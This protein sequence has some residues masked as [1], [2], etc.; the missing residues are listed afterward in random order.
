SSTSDEGTTM[1]SSGSRPDKNTSHSRR[2]AGWSA[3]PL[4]IA[5]RPFLLAASTMACGTMRGDEAMEKREWRCRSQVTCLQSDDVPEFIALGG[6]LGVH[7][8]LDH[9]LHL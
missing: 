8:L 7:E 5:T 2:H 4:P 3:S 9:V 1:T 6:A